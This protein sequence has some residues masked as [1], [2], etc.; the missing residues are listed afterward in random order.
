MAFAVAVG[1]LVAVAVWVG[2]LLAFIVSV[3]KDS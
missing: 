3:S 2:L 1:F